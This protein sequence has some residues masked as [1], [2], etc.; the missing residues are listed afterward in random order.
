MKTRDFL[1]PLEKEE[2]YGNDVA[3]VPATVKAVIQAEGVLP[4]G[5]GA[6]TVSHAPLAAAI[7]KASGSARGFPILSEAKSEPDYGSRSTA[8]SYGSLAGGASYTLWD[9]KDTVS[10][11]NYYHRIK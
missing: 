3:E 1:R 10:R 9:E 11:G 2:G 7:V 6:Y 4:S 5:V 8:T